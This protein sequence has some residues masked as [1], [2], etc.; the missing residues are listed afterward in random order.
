MR[1]TIPNTTNDKA[2]SAFIAGLHYHD[3]LRAKLLHKQPAERSLFGFS[4]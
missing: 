3:N 2:I 1:I 4:N